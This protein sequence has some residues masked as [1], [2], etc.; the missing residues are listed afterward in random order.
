MEPAYGLR[1][2]PP[3]NLRTRFYK[4]MTDRIHEPQIQTQINPITNLLY[5]L[6]QLSGLTG[7]TGHKSTSDSPASEERIVTYPSQNETLL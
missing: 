4:T 3:L 5:L 7:T 2:D 6:Q 1:N